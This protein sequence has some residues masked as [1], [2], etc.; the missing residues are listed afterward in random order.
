MTSTRSRITGHHGI[1]VLVPD[2]TS[3]TIVDAIIFKELCLGHI[4]PESR[5]QYLDIIH[6]LH[7]Q[8]AQAI[9]LGCT[10]IG[11]LIR[12]E[13]TRVPLYDTTRIHAAAAVE[14]ALP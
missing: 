14:M 8:G 6:Q 5:R 2:E 1:D 7:G 3:Q 10:E 13:D 4:N 9:I 11:L 12:S